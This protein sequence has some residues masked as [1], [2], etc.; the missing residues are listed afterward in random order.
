MVHL[1]GRLTGESLFALQLSNSQSA[2]TPAPFQQMLQLNLSNVIDSPN[3]LLNLRF[4]ADNGCQ[5]PLYAWVESY[6]S[7]LSQVVVWVKI[8]FAIPAGMQIP[9][10]MSKQ[11]VSQY[12]YTGMAPQLSSTY[13]Q[14]DNG[15][16]V[17]TFYDNFAGTSLNT[18]KWSSYTSSTT[19]TVNN[20]ITIQTSGSSTYGAIVTNTG[21]SLQTIFDAY[22][23]SFSIQSSSYNSAMGVGVQTANSG[24]AQGYQYTSWNASNSN[25]G[26][27][28]Y[29]TISGGITNF[30]A[31]PNFPNNGNAVLSGYWIATGNLGFAVNY[32]FVT[33]T[34]SNVSIGSANYYALGG[35]Y[36]TQS[37]TSVWYWARV[38]AMPPNNVMPSLVYFLRI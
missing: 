15:N 24:S 28:T 38:R 3:E 9:I 35:W 27:I 23:A 33:S 17:F 25:G 7:D 11:S 29:G 10:Y 37:A 32:N 16:N 36:N 2:P 14:Y 8:P 6:T 34:N 21:F 22:L 12:P 1:L 20:G 26:T 4:C 31:G 13:A 5:N 30:Q 18:N 19:I